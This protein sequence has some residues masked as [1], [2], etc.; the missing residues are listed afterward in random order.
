MKLGVNCL[1]SVNWDA[2]I[3]LGELPAQP[4]LRESLIF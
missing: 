3:E 4:P 1:L 2:M